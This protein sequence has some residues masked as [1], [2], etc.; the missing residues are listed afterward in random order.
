[1]AVMNSAHVR[2]TILSSMNDAYLG[3][4]VFESV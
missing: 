4:T 2:T 3:A 1:V